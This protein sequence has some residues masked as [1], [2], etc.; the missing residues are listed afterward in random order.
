MKG[1]KII[2]LTLGFILLFSLYLFLG[3]ICSY[4]NTVIYEHNDII[5]DA[6]IANY[7]YFAKECR[8]HFDRHPFAFILIPF[9]K[10]FMFFVGNPKFTLLIFQA[11]IAVLNNFLLFNVLRKIK[12]RLLTSVIFTLIYALSYG[13]LFVFVVYRLASYQLYFIRKVFRNSLFKRHSYCNNGFFMRLRSW[14]QSYKHS[15]V[16]T[17]FGILFLKYNLAERKIPLNTYFCDFICVYAFG[18]YYFK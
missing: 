1:I 11:G 18:F 15:V 9:L 5:Y 3:L 12:V 16:Y 8:V 2:K 17:A 7:E 6:D 13:N 4:Y 14:N 10:V